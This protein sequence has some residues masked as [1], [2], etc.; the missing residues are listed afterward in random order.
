MIIY[1]M[2]NCLIKKLETKMVSEFIVKKVARE[3]AGDIAWS[4]EPGKAMR[5]WRDI[6]NVSQTEISKIMDVAPS[7]ISDYEKGRRMPGSRF[8]KRY[9]EALLEAD[10]RNSWVTLRKLAK[11]MKIPSSAVIDIREFARAVKLKDVVKAVDGTILYGKEKME[12]PIY[13]YTIL[14]SIVSIESMS[15]YEFYNLMG[16]TTE[17][18]LIFT[19]VGTGRSPMVAVRVSTLKPGAVIVHGPK[20]VDPL[21]IKLS[22]KD[23]IPFILSRKKNVNELVSILRRIP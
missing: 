12:K 9:V 16:M 14:D 5:K 18:A 20:V 3:I 13:G 1:K 6:F 8:I 21:A 7:V 11:T 23:N 17:R 19:N 2:N 15:G 22:E 10:S 4:N